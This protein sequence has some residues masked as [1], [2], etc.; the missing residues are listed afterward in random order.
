MVKKSVSIDCYKI[1]L[2]TISE[3][4][5]SGIEYLQL[6]THTGFKKRLAKLPL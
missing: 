5:R 6:D 2:T 1:V 3:F 4:L